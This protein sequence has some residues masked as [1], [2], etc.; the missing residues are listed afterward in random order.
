M[1]YNP[2]TYCKT[3]IKF[4]RVIEN[5]CSPGLDEWNTLRPLSKTLDLSEPTKCTIQAV[6]EPMKVR[7]ISKG[8]SLPYYTCRPLQKALHSVLKKIS[9]FRLIGRPF[10][11][12]DMFDLKKRALPSDQWF[13]I[14]YSAATDGLSW[15]YSSRILNH[16]LSKV[17]PSLRDL[18]LKVLGP[19]DL[20]YPVKGKREIEFRGKQ[21]NGQLMGSI[22]SF[23][24]LCLANLGVYLSATSMFHWDWSDVDRLNHVLVNGDDMIYA[25]D[26]CLWYDHV[27]IAGEVGLEM[28]VGKAYQH[29]VYANINSTSIHYDL[30]D[31]SSTPYQI[32]Y[33]NSGLYFGQHKVQDK[34]DCREKSPVGSEVSVDCKYASEK[35]LSYLCAREHTSKDPSKG[36]CQNLNTILDGSWL[37]QERSLLK[38]FLELHKD[39]IKKECTMVLKVN[40]LC[41]LVTRNL[42]LPLSLGGMGVNSPAGWKYRISLNDRQ[43]A[44]ACLSENVAPITTQY[45]LPGYSLG[46]QSTLDCP[47]MKPKGSPSLFSKM[48]ETNSF[49]TKK[50]L[51]FLRSGCVRYTRT[52]SAISA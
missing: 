32:N 51:S 24:I 21:Q 11:P 39:E 17:D 38:E 41:H 4:G 40:R 49:L 25:A 43:I 15:K 50:S 13:S 52:R 22:L 7:V 6:L 42:F 18:A 33:L 36:L 12:T 5:R 46:S 16:V 23:P 9:C 30:S 10:S 29:R 37:G 2:K 31:S 27:R 19:H 35:E 48:I 34:V 20:H 14:D 45:P 44:K 1:S 47:W 26:K 28:S 8:E 3:G